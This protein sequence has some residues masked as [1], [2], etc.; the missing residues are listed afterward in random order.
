MSVV[1]GGYSD[2]LRSQKLPKAF[3]R[4]RYPRQSGCLLHPSHKR[5]RLG[6]L[7]ALQFLPSDR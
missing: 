6:A 2:I 7:M 1:R 5:Y 4:D 3:H